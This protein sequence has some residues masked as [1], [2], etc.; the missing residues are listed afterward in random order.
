MIEGI[1]GLR[2]LFTRRPRRGMLLIGVAVLVLAVVAILMVSG[3]SAQE[4]GG[5]PPAEAGPPG[6]GPGG[7]PGGGPGGPP[8]EPGMPGAPGGA[9]G[10]AAAAPAAAPAAEPP[11]GPMLTEA[12]LRAHI[13]QEGGWFDQI[14][15]EFIA[16]NTQAEAAFRQAITAGPPDDADLLAKAV[17]LRSEAIGHAET[18]WA[19]TKDADLKAKIETYVYVSRMQSNI[20]SRWVPYQ[21]KAEPQGEAAAK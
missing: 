12:D 7:P 3:V 15:K 18:I 4:E 14:I 5:P 9:A 10:G 21:R 11:K 16:A 17:Y 13:G 1:C 19:L 6:G 20:A 2:R 8:A